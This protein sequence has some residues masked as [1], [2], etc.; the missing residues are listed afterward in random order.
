MLGDD[1]KPVKAG[2]IGALCA[3]LP[4]PPGKKELHFFYGYASGVMPAADIPEAVRP[5]L[6]LA[7]RLGRIAVALTGSGIEALR[8]EYHGGI[9]EHD[10]RALTLSGL[11]GAFS[12]A[13]DTPIGWGPSLRERLADELRRG[14]RQRHVAVR[15]GE[16]IQAKV[17]LQTADSGARPV[18]VR[19]SLRPTGTPTIWRSPPKFA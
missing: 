19:P 8:F 10:T 15:R 16:G 18:P 2:D 7:E 14:C 6:Q 17:C 3:K 5:Y 12:A 4:L 1:K 11:K 13:R 9:A